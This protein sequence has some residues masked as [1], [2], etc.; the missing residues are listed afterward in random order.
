MSAI[1]FL[2]FLSSE[3][4]LIVFQFDSSS[5]YVRVALEMFSQKNKFTFSEII[6]VRHMQNQMQ[7]SH[8]LCDIDSL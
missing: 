3:L 1:A 2:L 6:F 4:N 7:M 5:L 8:S